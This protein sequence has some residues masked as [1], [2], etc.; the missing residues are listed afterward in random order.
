MNRQRVIASMVCLSLI[1]S[2]AAAESELVDAASIRV[3]QDF[4]LQDYR[5]K[6]HRLSDYDDSPVVVLAFL[7]TECPLVKLYGPR[8]QQ[9]SQHYESRGVAFLGINSN[10]QDSITD[11]A[12]YA[13]RHGVT[14]PVL[15]D[16]R[17][18]LADELKA[19]R[20]PSVIVLN[21]DRQPHLSRTD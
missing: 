9:L 3:V 20:T 2:L 14:F 15:K 19:E 11:M 1:S 13:R 6:R 8:L 16:V 5:G 4:S 12:A 17:N 7:G 10:R 21:V 18:K